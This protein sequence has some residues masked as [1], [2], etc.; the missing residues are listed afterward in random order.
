MALRCWIQGLPCPVNVELD[1]RPGLHA[2]LAST[3]LTELHPG[4]SD[5]L[6]K[7][8]NK[9]LKTTWPTRTDP[10]SPS[11]PPQDMAQKLTQEQW[12]GLPEL[13]VCYPFAGKSD[14]SPSFTW[15]ESNLIRKFLCISNYSK[16]TTSSPS[17]LPHFT[18]LLPQR[19]YLADEEPGLR[20]L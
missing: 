2:R 11:E 8:A 15:E 9:P 10:S 3:L 1:Q 12:A 14:Q 19:I 5:S 17:L 18:S 13:T 7:A 20:T 6:V 16:N 4:P